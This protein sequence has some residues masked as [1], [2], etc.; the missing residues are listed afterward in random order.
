MNKLYFLGAGGFARELYSYIKEYD[1]E[2]RNYQFAGFLSDYSDDLDDFDMIHGVV[3]NIRSDK[4]LEGDAILIAVANCK[5]KD[6][7]YHYYKNKN[8][9]ILS[10][11]HPMAY[12]GNNVTI[13]DGSV[14]CPYATLT[15]DIEVGKGVLINAHSSIGHDAVIGNFSTLSGHCDITGGVS[16]GERVMFGSH[17]L[18]IPNKVVESDSIVGAGSVVVKKVKSGTTVFGNPAKKIK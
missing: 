16:V 12:V 10:F 1:F 15:A 6:E 8:C 3:D 14:I 17:A 13:G 4:V 9:E 2:Y 7:L 18:V 5:L 11:I